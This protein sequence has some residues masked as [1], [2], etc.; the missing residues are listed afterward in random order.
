MGYCT[1]KV[2]WFIEV[3]STWCAL[4]GKGLVVGEYL[5]VSNE[6]EGKNAGNN[7]YFIF[8][9]NFYFR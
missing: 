1:I 7:K 2:Y 8:V 3:P 6:S 4:F 5:G 9:S